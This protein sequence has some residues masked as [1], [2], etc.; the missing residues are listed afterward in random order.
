MV[1]IFVKGDQHLNANG[2]FGKRHTIGDEPSPHAC[3]HPDGISSSS[4]ILVG[5]NINVSA[6]VY[7]SSELLPSAGHHQ[8]QLYVLTILLEFILL[9]SSSQK[10]NKIFILKHELCTFKDIN[11]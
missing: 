2:P 6:T 10:V 11:K 3:N 1:I 7:S 9:T 4:T 8:Y 5:M